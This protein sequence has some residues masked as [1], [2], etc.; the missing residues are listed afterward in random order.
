MGRKK[1][2]TTKQKIGQLDGAA[3]NVDD[4]SDESGTENNSDQEI[5]KTR[6][7]HVVRLL[8][9]NARSLK[10]K[11]GSL[12]QA[13]G[14][15]ELDIACVTETWYKGGR[16]LNEHLIEV[17][18]KMGIK[19]IH[20]SR[21]GRSRKSGGGV[22]IAFNASNCNLKARGLKHVKRDHEV[23]C[24][25][26]VVGKIARKIV[27]FAVYVPPSMRA[28]ELE[29]LRE[30]LATEISAAAKAFKDPVILVAG[31]FNH[32]D[33]GEA[34]NE[35]GEFT[36]LATAPTRGTN[37]I[38]L[39][40]TNDPE[41]HLDTRVLPPLDTAGGTLSDH[42]CVFTEARFPPVK[43]FHWV[44]ELRRTR[45][46]RR[47]EAFA[48]DMKDWNWEGLRK[49]GSADDMAKTLEETIDHLTNK[50]FPL[51]RVRKRSN[52][53]PWITRRIRRMWKRKIRLY[54]KKGKSQAWWNT[55]RALQERITEAKE[56][57]VERLLED[58]NA[59]R[60]FYA[61]TRK[62]ATCTTAPQ[63]S[64]GDL[65]PGQ[66]P[67]VVCD[68]VL[69]FYGR[70]ACAPAPPM[71]SI[72]C[73]GGGLGDFSVDR[74]TA[75]LKA[76][77][78]TDSR[79]DGDPLPHLV[80]RH[81][82]AFAEPITMLF[83]EI[84]RTGQWP[85]SWKTEHLTVIPKVPNPSGLAEC[86]NISCTSIFSKVLE[87]VLLE[88]LRGELIPDS[89]Q[90]GGK[91]KCGAEHMLVDMW[92]KIMVSLEGGKSAA[93]L[94][95]VDYEKAFN[96][97]EHD[98]CLRQLRQL[99]AS[100][101]SLVMVKAFLENRTMTLKIGTHKA[102][103]IKIMRGSPQGSV[104]GC[105]L[106]C[107]TTQLLT[108]NLRDGQRWA[109][110][111]AASANDGAVAFQY[112]D[113]T[114][115]VDT[116]PL[117][118]ATRHFTEATTVEE[119]M[120]PAIAGDFDVLEERAT[121]IGMAINGKKTQLL[122]VSP[123]NGC[124]TV[125]TLATRSGDTVKSVDSMKLVGFTFGDSPGVGAHVQTIAEKYK[126][127][128]WMLYH[129]RNAGFRGTHLYK[130]YCC[131]VRSVIEYCSPVYHPLLNGSQE[132]RLER[133]QRHALRVCYGSEVPVER[134]MEEHN[135]ATLRERRVRRCD[136]FIKKAAAN[137][138]FAPSWFPRR[139]GGHMG[140]RDRREV[141]ETQATTCRRFNSPL[142]FFRRRANQLGVVPAGPDT[143]T[144]SSSLDDAG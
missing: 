58:G 86:R 97:M 4:S 105:L 137:P 72:G 88:R 99:G 140:L 14:S 83:N 37:T 90:Y 134:V 25:V 30:S 55:E 110:D 11:I 9:T 49:A 1:Q 28:A 135:I 78:K 23:V 21:D 38:D 81:P 144:E 3:D 43:N 39:I 66:G 27:I 129:L 2:H 31:D 128:K 98:V 48:Q 119:I 118:S 64:V 143:E 127:K 111:G 50:H 16:E 76:V 61:A 130:L 94:L 117:E 26:G 17:E 124:R 62:L 52:E 122:V 68:E 7:E 59:G 5:N 125:A 12:H 65:F 133:L 101:G 79:V 93:V 82:E 106:Y 87:G 120:Q 102:K 15:L 77:K 132:L 32:R 29:S 74:T 42:R 35:V 22:A 113:D 19:M 84:N 115:L 103:P 136:S 53:S 6:D 92:E 142:S 57:F 36:A 104:L 109:Q 10:P 69:K 18:G 121:N 131:Y 60:S 85:T 138:L 116:V 91:P 123:P 40:Y 70:I 34:I 20:K 44:S 47:E 71:P 63:W 139:P 67:E 33:I 96:R 51:A 89:S 41:A 80:R 24:A 141:A 108:K 75:L 46:Q 73:G 56:N 112:V 126:R 95:G 45:D 100:E 114:T 8:L 107:I 13:F 54:K